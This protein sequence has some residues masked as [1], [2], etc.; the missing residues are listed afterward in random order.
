[1]P[2]ATFQEICARV[3]QGKVRV[4]EHGRQELADDNVS[5]KDVIDRL[6]TAEV[7]EDYPD[8][9]KGPAVLCLQTDRKGQPMHV[10][11]GISK[12]T[13]DVATIIT[14]YRPDPARWMDDWMTRKSK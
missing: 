2:N 10:L 8:Y 7:I 1:M 13:P 14:A 12:R 9:A 6:E 4:S 11:W 5:L 3:A